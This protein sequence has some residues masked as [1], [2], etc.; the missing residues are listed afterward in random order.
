LIESDAI[1]WRAVDAH[2]PASAPPAEEWPVMYDPLEA[3]IAEVYRKL[4]YPFDGDVVR[5]WLGELDWPRQRT[6]EGMLLCLN[7]AVH[8]GFTYRRRNETG[9]LTPAQ[10]LESRSGS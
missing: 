7:Q 9:V 2:P 8:R 1:V 4:V 5:D 6:A 3:D 10:V